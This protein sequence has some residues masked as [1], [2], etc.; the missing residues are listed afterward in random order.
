MAVGASLGCSVGTSVG[1]GV[2]V[3]GTAGVGISVA[4]EVGN[5]LV[6]IGVRIFVLAGWSVRVH[7]GVGVRGCG[8]G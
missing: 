6:G 4:L 7:T 2:T 3:G 5:G 8:S 1:S